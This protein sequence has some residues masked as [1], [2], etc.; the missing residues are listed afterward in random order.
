[1]QF[2]IATSAYCREVALAIVS[3]QEPEHLR[4]IPGGYFHG[5]VRK[6]KAGELHFERI[7]RALRRAA[8]VQKPR[9]GPERGLERGNRRRCRRPPDTSPYRDWF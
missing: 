2:E 3:N 6:A 9:S 1:M 8:Q 7:R 4:T 5:I